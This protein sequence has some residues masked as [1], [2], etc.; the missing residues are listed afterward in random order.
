MNHILFFPY[1]LSFIL[2]FPVTSVTQSLQFSTTLLI[3]C[4]IALITILGNVAMYALIL[5]NARFRKQVH[6]IIFQNGLKVK[7][8]MFDI[9]VSMHSQL[10]SVI[11]TDIDVP[12]PL[13]LAIKPTA[14]CKLF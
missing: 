1:I 10:S 9:Y 13:V 2:P 8:M 5:T 7:Y 3:V 14:L 6:A 12:C 11:W 4:V